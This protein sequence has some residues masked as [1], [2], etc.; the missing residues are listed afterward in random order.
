MAAAMRR[1]V[2]SS[3]V[4]T[5]APETCARAGRPGSDC[6]GC[7]LGL[8]AVAWAKAVLASAGANSSTSPT[9]T[10]GHAR[11]AQ[12]FLK[13]ITKSSRMLKSPPDHAQDAAT[14]DCQARR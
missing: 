12:M 14:D 1:A 6:A 11:V 10:P 3:S 2:A 8:D 5:G 9:R 13:K 4:G 7:G